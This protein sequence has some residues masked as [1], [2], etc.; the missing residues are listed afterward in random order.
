MIVIADIAATRII[1]IMW[2]DL[3]VC[4]VSHS[5]LV[6]A[7]W[8][9]LQPSPRYPKEKVLHPSENKKVNKNMNDYS[10][11]DQVQMTNLQVLNL[12]KHF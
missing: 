2:T 7:P 6:E 1:I 8:L 10:A 12:K 11:E 5:R 9:E 4:L 3:V